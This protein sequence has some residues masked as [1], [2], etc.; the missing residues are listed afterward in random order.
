[1]ARIMGEKQEGKLI[2]SPSAQNSEIHWL[3]VIDSVLYIYLIIFHGPLLECT[4]RLNLHS[5]SA[6]RSHET[7]FWGER[8][9]G[10]RDELGNKASLSFSGNLLGHLLHM[11]ASY[12]R[13]IPGFLNHHLC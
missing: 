11:A 3:P 4:K 2:L 1:M 5:L 7:G 12:Y 8:H 9:V 6:V 10:T 13:K